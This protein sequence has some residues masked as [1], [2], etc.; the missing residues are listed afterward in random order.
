MT[1]GA[2]EALRQALEE[3]GIE[4]AWM[5]RD[6]KPDYIHEEEGGLE[7]WGAFELF[8]NHPAPETV[9]AVGDPGGIGHEHVVYVLAEN[10]HDLMVKL[11]KIA[12]RMSTDPESL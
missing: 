1:L 2:G 6:A 8:K 12:D 7:A 9:Q 3:T 11:R 5:N 10:V 4:V